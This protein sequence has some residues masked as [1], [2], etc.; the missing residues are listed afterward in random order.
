MVSDQLQQL[1]MQKEALQ[2]QLQAQPNSPNKEKFTTQLQ[3]RQIKEKALQA[4]KKRVDTQ[5]SEQG[6][7]ILRLRIVS[8]CSLWCLVFCLFVFFFDHF[9]V[10]G[11]VSDTNMS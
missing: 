5:L 8:C 9:C 4:D 11:R 7:L 3:E 6:E 2:Q 10:D 1:S